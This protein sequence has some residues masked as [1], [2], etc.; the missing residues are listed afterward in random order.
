MPVDTANS[1][2][3]GASHT[4]G[5]RPQNRM[6]TPLIPAAA[7]VTWANMGDSPG[8]IARLSDGIRSSGAERCSTPGMFTGGSA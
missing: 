2:S 1:K 3:P 7:L 6:K 4:P 5:G 8:S